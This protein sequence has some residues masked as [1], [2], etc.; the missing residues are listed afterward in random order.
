[1]NSIKQTKRPQ[2][3]GAGEDYDQDVYSYIAGVTGACN[4]ADGA[5]LLVLFRYLL[6]LLVLHQ[7]ILKPHL[8]TYLELELVLP[9]L[10]HDLY[11]QA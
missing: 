10:L 9:L 11:V 5:I 4:K 2:M 7:L 8:L 1:M 3:R 6:D